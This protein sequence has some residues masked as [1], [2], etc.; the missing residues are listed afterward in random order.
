MIEPPRLRNLLLSLGLI[1][2]G[3]NAVLS[4]ALG[5]DLRACAIALIGLLL[6]QGAAQIGRND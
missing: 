6:V 4:V 5:E 3:S 1:T 2:A